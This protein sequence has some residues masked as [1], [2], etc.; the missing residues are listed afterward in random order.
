LNAEPFERRVEGD[1]YALSGFR[2][3]VRDGEKEEPVFENEVDDDVGGGHG[4]SYCT[5]GLRHDG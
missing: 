2:T 1:V 3:D 5:G 4:V